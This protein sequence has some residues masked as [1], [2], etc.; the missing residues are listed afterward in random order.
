MENYQF[1][2]YSNLDGYIY[3]SDNENEAITAYN[4]YLNYGITFNGK[5]ID[6]T[7]KKTKSKDLGIILYKNGEIFKSYTGW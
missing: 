7:P 2:I 6:G 5:K 4:N 3:Y 1:V